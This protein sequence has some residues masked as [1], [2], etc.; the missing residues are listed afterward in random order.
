[1]T[2]TTIDTEAVF[3][4]LERIAEIAS[5]I[6]DGEEAKAIITEQAMGHIV[7][8]HPEFRYMSGDYY[9]VDHAMFLRTKKLLMRIERLAKVAVCS[10]LWLPVPQ[11]D[12]VTVVVQNGP[13]HRYYAFGQIKQATPPEMK[14]VFETG[15]MRRAP[16]ADGGKC[17]A[18]LAPVRDSLGDV[19]AVL[20]LSSPLNRPPAWN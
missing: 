17:A 9:D 15:E 7:H 3:A 16:A 8:P 20:E 11:S 12:D 13:T 5:G 4:E 2:D 10:A 18:V 6:L 1:M 19:A 14:Q